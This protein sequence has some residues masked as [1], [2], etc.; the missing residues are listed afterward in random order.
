MLRGQPCPFYQESTF[1]VF[2][3]NQYQKLKLPKIVVDDDIFITIAL[4]LAE[5][6]YYSGDLVKI[7]Q[8][9][10]NYIMLQYNYMQFVNDFNNEVIEL[11]KETN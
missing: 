7:M 8:T 6:G 10:V 4:S 1:K 11:N 2:K 9:P 3:S 5:K